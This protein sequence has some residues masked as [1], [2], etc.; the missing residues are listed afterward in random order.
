M[1]VAA[2][3]LV[4]MGAGVSVALAAEVRSQPTP[5]L[6]RAMTPSAVSVEIADPDPEPVPSPSATVATPVVDPTVPPNAQPPK[7]QPPQYIPPPPPPPAPPATSPAEAVAAAASVGQSRGAF[8]GV[9]VLD[10]QTGQVY[11]AGSPD[12]YFASASVMKVFIATRLLVEGHHSNPN[13]AS[14]MWS[15]IVAS[16]DN[17]ASALYPIVGNESLIPWIASRYGLGGLAP[18]TIPNWW[19]LTRITARS[20]VYFYNAVAND[21]AVG[22]W[23]LTAMGS[24]SG[25]GSDG[26]YQYFG[27]PSATSGWRVKQG[28]MCCLENRTRMHSTGFINGDRYAVALLTDGTRGIYGSYGAQTLTL[29]AGALLPGGSIPHPP[30]PPSTPTPEPTPTP[31]PTPTSTPTPTPTPTLTPTPTPTPE[32]TP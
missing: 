3:V 29:M 12:T 31:T 25:Y 6:H 20:M 8:V 17:A 15:M 13:I 19:G 18:A 23:L 1:P 5:I 24:A 11:T 27:I 4:L 9:A 26:F 14:K 16:D 30:P 32:P 2:A 22:P 21:P 28:W 10:R 7:Q